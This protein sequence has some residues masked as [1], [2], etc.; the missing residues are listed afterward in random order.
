MNEIDQLLIESE[1]TEAELG[2]FTAMQE[3]PSGGQNFLL[4]YSRDAEGNDSKCLC[5]FQTAR[6]VEEYMVSWGVPL[7]GWRLMGGASPK[8]CLILLEEVGR[9][10]DLA[11]INPPLVPSGKHSVFR[12]GELADMLRG[13]LY[14]MTLQ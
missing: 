10:I 6:D 13:W 7:E 3:N 5:L 11:I 8:R 9:A 12:V 14:Q 4:Y 1:E 2:F